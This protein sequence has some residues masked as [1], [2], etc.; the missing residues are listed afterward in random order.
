M[1]HFPALRAL[2]RPYLEAPLYYDWTVQGFGMM[3]TY[4]GPDKLWR[5][6]V[7]NSA[8]AV[9][10]V[11]VIHNHPWHFESWIIAGNFTN[12]RYTEHKIGVAYH[13]ATIKTGEGGGIRSKPD[14][15]VLQFHR[16]EHYWPGQTYKQTADEIHQSF[17]SDGCVTL[18]MR[19]RVGDGEHARVYWPAGTAWVDADPRPA[20][21]AEV[22]DTAALALRRWNV[23]I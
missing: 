13:F 2:V 23:G 9:P 14:N 17:Y 7:W 20:T 8:L 11:S 3:R 6:N 4:I 22:E 10:N 15:A 16:D 1:S 19:Q 5:L 21:E 12:R 18:N